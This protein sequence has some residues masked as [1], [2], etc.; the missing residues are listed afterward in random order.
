[1][2]GTV[3]IAFLFFTLITVA[4]KNFTKLGFMIFCDCEITNVACTFQRESVY[5]TLVQL[6]DNSYFFLGAWTKEYVSIHQ[7]RT[8]HENILC[9]P[10]NTK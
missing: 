7:I 3:T 6:K 10:L 9:M 1:M 5:L 2:Y 8:I 4:F